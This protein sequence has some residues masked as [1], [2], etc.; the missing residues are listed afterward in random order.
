M[1]C[2]CRMTQRPGFS[3]IRKKRNH[4]TPCH[5]FPLATYQILRPIF[6]R[7]RAHVLPS[8]A[9]FP[10]DE[11]SHAASS[12]LASLLP[13]A[14]PAVTRRSG[15]GAAHFHPRCPPWSSNV[16]CSLQLPS[17]SSWP[18]DL[19]ALGHDA[20][21]SGR[22]GLVAPTDRCSTPLLRTAAVFFMGSLS[23]HPLRH[24]SAPS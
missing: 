8:L 15:C 7:P 22:L 23:L 14:N 16:T 13:C 12:L 10:S 18:S 3:L 9:P 2:M 4:F 11:T 1:G 20:A 6:Y 21:G 5:Y 17:R 19:A 24:V